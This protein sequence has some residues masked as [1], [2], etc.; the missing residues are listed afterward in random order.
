[1][2]FEKPFFPIKTSGNILL[3]SKLRS[4]KV[5]YIASFTVFF[6]PV[7]IEDCY[8]EKNQIIAEN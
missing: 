7:L 2:K 1:M 5:K 3:G 8:L 4:L 6:V